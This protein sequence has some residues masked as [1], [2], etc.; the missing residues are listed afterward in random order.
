MAAYI[1]NHMRENGVLIGTTGRNY[2]TLK[3]RPPLVFRKEHAEILLAAMTKAL[4]D[5]LSLKSA[6]DG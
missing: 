5:V 6:R 1:M 2:A 3:V 4:D